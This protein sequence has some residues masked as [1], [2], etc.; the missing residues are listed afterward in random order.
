MFSGLFCKCLSYFTTAKMFFTSTL[1]TVTITSMI[2]CPI[3]RQKSY[4]R[5]KALPATIREKEKRKRKEK[6]KTLELGHKLK[7]LE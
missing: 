6:E 2:H 3:K 7:L 5:R 4:S 1:L